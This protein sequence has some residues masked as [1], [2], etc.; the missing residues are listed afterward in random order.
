MNRLRPTW[1]LVSPP[2]WSITI[3]RYNPGISYNYS[4]YIYIYTHMS[5]YVYMYYD[6]DRTAY[7]ARAKIIMI[8]FYHLLHN[9]YL[10]LV[11]HSLCKILSVYIDASYFELQNCHASAFWKANQAVQASRRH[12]H[13]QHTEIQGQ[14]CQRCGPGVEN[15]E[16][17]TILQES[18]T[19]PTHVFPT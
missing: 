4:V 10:T 19:L 13:P 7:S 8:C 3:E 1:F 9:S 17:Q 6:H 11:W 16:W 14:H 5:M 15:A 18:Y 2:K 12:P